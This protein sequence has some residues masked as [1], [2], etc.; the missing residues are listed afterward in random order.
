MDFVLYNPFQLRSTARITGRPDWAEGVRYRGLWMV[1]SV[2]WLCVQVCLWHS[3]PRK[4]TAT[5]L[6]DPNLLTHKALQ[7]DTVWFENKLYFNNFF[8]LFSQWPNQILSDKWLTIY[9]FST[10]VYAKITISVLIVNALQKHWNWIG[11][12]EN[13]NSN[14]SRGNVTSRHQS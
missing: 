1:P 10:H 14:R 6:K 2:T 9:L 13:R 12:V 4:A 7:Y 5:F 11:K 8:K 3:V